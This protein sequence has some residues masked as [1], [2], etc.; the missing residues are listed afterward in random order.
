MQWVVVKGMPIGGLFGYAFMRL[1]RQFKKG[2]PMD[3]PMY[4]GMPLLY[5]IYAK[6]TTYQQKL[7][8]IGYPAHP[9]IIEKRRKCINNCC[10]FAP[11]MVKNEIEYM[12]AKIDGI[13][14]ED[15]LV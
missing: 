15:D 6:M 10:F 1:I 13:N 14:S 8:E 7:F 5:W 12:H 4:F 3:W 2:S 9:T 11:S